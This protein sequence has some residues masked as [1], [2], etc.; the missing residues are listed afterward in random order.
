MKK[1]IVSGLLTAVLA[2][3]MLSACG[4]T[5]GN[6]NGSGQQTGSGSTEN[7]AESAGVKMSIQQ[8]VDFTDTFPT[9]IVKQ[10]AEEAGIDAEWLN[11]A[12]ADWSDK[13]NLLLASGNIPD[14]FFGC[15]LTDSDVMSGV[16]LDLA[17]YLDSMPNVQKFFETYPDAKAICTT[18]DG[19]I[20]GIP[21]KIALRAETYNTLFINK[22]W[23]DKLGL[24]IPTTT[25]EFYEV[26]K[27]F[28]EQDPNGN[29]V[30]DEIGL[31]GVGV[32]NNFP[33]TGASTLADFFPAFGVVANYSD[34]YCMVEDGEVIFCP[35]M[36]NYKE[37]LKWLN[38]LYSEGLMD[39]EYFSNEWADYTAKIRNPEG[40]MVGAGTAWTVLDAVGADRIDDYVEIMPLI[41]PDGDQYW[42]SNAAAVGMSRNVFAVSA[43]CKDPEAACRFLNLCMDEYNGFQIAY[44]SE[45]V[46]VTKDENGNPAFLPIPD[47]YTDGEWKHQNGYDTGAP[48]YASAEFN[49]SITGENEAFLKWKSNEA[50]SKYFKTDTQYPMILWDKETLD[51]LAILQTDINGYVDQMLVDFI[52]NGNIEERWD[53][54][55]T[56][57][58]NMGL[59]RLLTIYKEGYEKNKN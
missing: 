20:Y 4:Q 22:T 50:Y 7:T 30:K 10:L 41:G 56:S 19:K 17:P 55:V 49:A 31:T 23:L 9:P 21:S 29:G 1:K 43:S 48:T 42:N 2:V 14:I 33:G 28:V 5:G 54:Y 46:G 37:A 18:E 38:R 11:V 45:G 24:E 44:G 58:D 26:M 35:T 25:E 59:D 16:F 6:G 15:S 51:E 52:T 34:T 3:S 27:A 36:D 47:G 39:K 40:L 57:L 8:V 32:W 12:G 13:K 53:A